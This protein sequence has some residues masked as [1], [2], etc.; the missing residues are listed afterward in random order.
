MSERNLL[1]ELQRWYA[2]NCDGDWEHDWGAKIGTLDNPGWSVDL[3]LERTPLEDEAFTEVRHHA[4]DDDWYT[5]RVRDRVFQGRG[6]ALNLSDMLR[7]F[8][9]WQ[10]S[11]Q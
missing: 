9:D 4:S 8:L 11:D 6:G 1:D 3:N 5:C 2:S 7:V 10:A